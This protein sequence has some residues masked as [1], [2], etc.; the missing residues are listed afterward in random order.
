MKGI[1]DVAC[2]HELGNGFFDRRDGDRVRSEEPDVLPSSAARWFVRKEPDAILQPFPPVASALSIRSQ[3]EANHRRPTVASAAKA[4]QHGA[5]HQSIGHQA[6]A[7]RLQVSFVVSGRYRSARR[8]AQ[9]AH[10][11]A[12]AKLG[13]SDYGRYLCRLLS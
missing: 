3:P 5:D 10:N 4:P 11:G 2:L 12:I 13:K 6:T 8:A 7:T 1:G 9:P